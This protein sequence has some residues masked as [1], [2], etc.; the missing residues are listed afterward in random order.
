[1][2]HEP[3]AARPHRDPYAAPRAL[4]A[5]TVG[6]ALLAELGPGPTPPGPDRRALTEAL[7]ASSH[8]LAALVI[9]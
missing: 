1:M 9:P 6:L 2:P 5:L 8:Q 3:P 7:A 4:T